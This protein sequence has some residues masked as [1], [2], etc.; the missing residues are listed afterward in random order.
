MDF[1]LALSKNIPGIQVYTGSFQ[2]FTDI[3][4]SETIYYKE[5]PLNIGYKGNEEPRDW[6]TDDVKECFS[7]FFGY[8]KK[9]ERLLY[10]LN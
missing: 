5:H 7:S 3:Y 10:K 8:W 4:K 1:M 9:V 2:S 6:I